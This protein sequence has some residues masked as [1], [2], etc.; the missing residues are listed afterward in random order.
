MVLLKAGLQ[1]LYYHLY[2]K[3]GSYNATDNSKDG[4]SGVHALFLDFRKAFDLLDHGILLWKL[5]ELNVKKSFWLWIKS[6]LEG[7]SQQ[8]RLDG[9]KSRPVTCPAGVP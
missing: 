2:P 3:I 4:R 5:A 9:I 6:F 7:R 8:V 1:Y